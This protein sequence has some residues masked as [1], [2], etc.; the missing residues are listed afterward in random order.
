MPRLESLPIDWKKGKKKKKT[1]LARVFP[2]GEGSDGMGGTGEER[3]GGSDGERE[4]ERERVYARK[5]SVALC[6]LLR[7]RFGQT[8]ILRFI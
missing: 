4:R 6:S 7:P 1:T 3:G 2:R 5:I 8:L